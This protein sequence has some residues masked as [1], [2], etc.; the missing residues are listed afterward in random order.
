MHHL[1]RNND[2]LLNGTIITRGWLMTCGQM[3]TRRPLHRAKLRLQMRGMGLGTIR[4]SSCHW[5]FRA[6][7]SILYVF[8]N[9]RECIVRLSYPQL[10]RTYSFIYPFD[11]LKWNTCPK[12]GIVNTLSSRKSIHFPAVDHRSHC[13]HVHGPLASCCLLLTVPR[14]CHDDGRAADAPLAAS[15][16]CTP[17]R[18]PQKAL[19]G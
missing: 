16:E 17:A 4:K 18:R 10:L 8:C 15:P 7:D 2:M 3:Q 6:L 9:F 11:L 5:R 12:C 19:R 14:C 1:L 13:L